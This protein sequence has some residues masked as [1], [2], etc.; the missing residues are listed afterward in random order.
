MEEMDIAEIEATTGI[1]NATV[2]VHLSRAV[3][4][5]RNKLRRLK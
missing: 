1:S 3:R 2:R 5:V 4:V